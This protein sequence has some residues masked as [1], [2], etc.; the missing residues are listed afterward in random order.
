MHSYIHYTSL[1]INAPRGNLYR[2]RTLL[3]SDLYTRIHIHIVKAEQSF[4][5]RNEREAL[6]RYIVDVFL[7]RTTTLL[8]TNITSFSAGVRG[9]EAYHF[10][11]RPHTGDG[12]SSVYPGNVVFGER[13]RKKN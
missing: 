13:E 2:P 8:S 5:H 6:D 1:S 12:L 11:T 4:I 9:N 10:E 3:Q 7:K